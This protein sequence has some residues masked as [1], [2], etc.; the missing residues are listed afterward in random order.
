M[1]I[2]MAY[3]E[4]FIEY[5]NTMGQLTGKNELFESISDAYALLE[6]KET[7]DWSE[8]MKPGQRIGKSERNIDATRE[9]N[10]NPVEVRFHRTKTDYVPAIQAGGLKRRN[11][12]YGQNTGDHNSYDNV[13]WTADNP[14]RVPVL[15]NFGKEKRVPPRYRDEI[16]T[17][18]VTMPKKDYEDT[19]RYCMPG[20]RSRIQSGFPVTGKKKSL[21]NEGPYKVDIF[22]QD[23]PPE[24][25]EL[26]PRNITVNG[27][28]EVNKFREWRK[29]HRSD[30]E[31]LKKQLPSYVTNSF[32]G[33]KTTRRGFEQEGDLSNDAALIDLIAD[34]I[35]DS[36]RGDTFDWKKFKDNIANGQT[37]FDAARNSLVATHTNRPWLDK[38]EQ[39][40]F[41]MNSGHISNARDNR[42]VLN[43][44]NSDAKAKNYDSIKAAI[45]N[46]E[47]S[48]I[49]QYDTLFKSCL[50]YGNFNEK[51]RDFYEKEHE[52]LLAADPMLNVDAATARNISKQVWDTYAADTSEIIEQAAQTVFSHYPNLSDFAKNFLRKHWSNLT[53][54][55]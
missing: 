51:L 36:T 50:N 7:V 10:A 2:Y 19:K 34:Y 43:M 16:S 14:D 32:K 46:D 38:V 45:A 11:E 55:I 30:W 39:H 53:S 42:T 5:L 37:P 1:V 4:Q 54:L 23:I 17:F 52:A 26:L 15:R 44:R 8:G 31:A 3:S 13:I 21:S 18:R 22:M 9:K 25:L 24:F 35:P 48:S 6:M 41:T 27:A 40:Q 49:A 12:N 33:T 20:G 29:T 47:N 28:L